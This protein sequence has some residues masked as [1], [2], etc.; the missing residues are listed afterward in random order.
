[1][2]NQGMIQ[3]P[4]NYH[5]LQ[6][7]HSLPS[8]LDG[9]RTFCAFDTET[10]GRGAKY[11]RVV[12]IG[13]VRFGRDGVEGTFGSLV[14][15]EKP[16]PPFITDIN[17]ITDEMV[18]DAPPASEVVPEFVKFAE[19]CILVAH[20]APFDLQFINWE[21]IRLGAETLRNSAVDTLRLTRWAY[22]D[23]GH[24]NQPFLAKTFGIDAGCAHRACDD[25]RVCME[26]F[27]RT[28]EAVRSRRLPAQQKSP[29]PPPRA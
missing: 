20:N 4:R 8:L 9:G 15:P 12:E 3:E 5:L 19:G 29:T 24:W 14:N 6:D 25:A 28:V 16:I 13:A 10:T 21:L 18:A 17:H 2:Y 1:M 7:F 11:E 26:L 27:S 22:P 23:L